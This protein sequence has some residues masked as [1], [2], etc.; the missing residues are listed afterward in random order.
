MQ[1]TARVLSLPLKSAASVGR[2]IGRE[3]PE[4]VEDGVLIGGL[5]GGVD[6]NVDPA[7]AVGVLGVEPEYRRPVLPDVGHR[8]DRLRR[9]PFDAEYFHA[10]AGNTPIAFTQR[11][12]DPAA[13]HRARV[14]DRT[15]IVQ[16]DVAERRV[17]VLGGLGP[18]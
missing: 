3:D 16:D 9:G 8:I 12:R 17:D 5:L 7:V 11:H 4:P 15:G 1:A 14:P 6:N 10:L 2:R 18:V 13:C